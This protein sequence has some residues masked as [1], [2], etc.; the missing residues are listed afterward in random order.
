MKYFDY[1]KHIE[2]YLLDKFSKDIDEIFDLESALSDKVKNNPERFDKLKDQCVV[3]SALS[4]LKIEGIQF[5][6]SRIDRLD[7]SRI[8]RLIEMSEDED[9]LDDLSRVEKQ[10]LGL[11]EVLKTIQESY[12]YIPANVNMILQ[13]HRDMYAYVNKEL[14]GNYRNACIFVNEIGEDGKSVPYFQ[15][16]PA[17]ETMRDLNE[18]SMHYNSLSLSRNQAFIADLM[19]LLDYYV[20]HPFNFGNGESMRFVANLLFNRRGLS[21]FNY[22]SMDQIM[23]EN[24]RDFY[25]SIRESS[26]NYDSDGNAYISIVSYFIKIM[27]KAYMK[28]N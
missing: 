24:I 4:S 16:V 6:D 12:M 1:V 8:D 18:L 23:L 9:D 13:L 26:H 28:I 7:D 27:K 10:L 19:F 15:P 11:I 14:G 3:D 5:D 25:M 2:D 17:H 21:I 22:V 20:I